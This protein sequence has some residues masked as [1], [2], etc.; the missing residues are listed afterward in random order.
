MNDLNDVEIQ[1]VFMIRNLKLFDKLEI[2]Y[3]KQGELD[4]QLTECHRGRY[5]IDIKS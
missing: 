2:K 1:L 4:W 3:S 5:E